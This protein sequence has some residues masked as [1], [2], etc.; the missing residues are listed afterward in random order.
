MRTYGEHLIILDQ[1]FKERAQT[2]RVDPFHVI[3][4]YGDKLTAGC[5][6][7]AVAP[8]SVAPGFVLCERNRKRIVGRIDSIA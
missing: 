3:V 6:N 7:A 1:G 4:G 8:G 2:H 5:G